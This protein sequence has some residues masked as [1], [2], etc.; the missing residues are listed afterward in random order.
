[1]KK[2]NPDWEPEDRDDIDISGSDLEQ[3][4]NALKGALA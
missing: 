4:R 1:M 3:L 2:V